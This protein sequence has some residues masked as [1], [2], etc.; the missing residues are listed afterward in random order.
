MKPDIFLL[1]GDILTLKMPHKWSQVLSADRLFLGAS[2][3]QTTE[4]RNIQP[5]RNQQAP[6]WLR[7]FCAQKPRAAVV[8]EATE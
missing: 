6:S 1:E 8:S 3:Q 5:G 7:V 4:S 2:A